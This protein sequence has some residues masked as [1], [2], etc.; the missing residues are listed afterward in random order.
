MLTILKLLLLQWAP[1]IPK[2]FLRSVPRAS[3]LFFVLGYLLGSG[4]I[5]SDELDSL[6]KQIVAEVQKLL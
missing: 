6:A 5:K 4:Y 3:V 2:W 1:A